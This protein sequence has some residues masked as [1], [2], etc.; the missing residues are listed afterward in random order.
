MNK[1]IC[2]HML[3]GTTFSNIPHNVSRRASSAY[4]VNTTSPF[5]V[6][7]APSPTRLRALPNYVLCWFPRA[8]ADHY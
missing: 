8:F 5:L 4:R 1:I 7:F 2:L 3:S 6:T